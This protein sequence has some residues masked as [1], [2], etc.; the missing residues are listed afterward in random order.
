MLSAEPSIRLAVRVLGFEFTTRRVEIAER[1]IRYV[2][3]RIRLFQALEI[4][5]R[6]LVAA[7]GARSVPEEMSANRL[8]GSAARICL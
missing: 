3:R 1:K 8:T 5:L 7:R 4:L 2:Q 6:V